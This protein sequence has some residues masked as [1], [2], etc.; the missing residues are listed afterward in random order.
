MKKITSLLMMFMLF[1]G[2]GWAQTPDLVTDGS[3]VYSIK[4]GRGYLGVENDGTYFR[5]IEGN[6]N[7]TTNEKLQWVFY[8]SGDVTYLYNVGMAEFA[9]TPNQ[10]GI[11]F[12]LTGGFTEANS[13]AKISFRP[14]TK[15]KNV[16]GNEQTYPWVL[17]LTDFKLHFANNYTQNVHGLLNYK[18]DADAGSQVAISKIEG[19]NVAGLKEQIAARL[20]AKLNEGKVVESLDQLSN[21]K[22]YYL[23]NMDNRG[24]F[25]YDY[26][27]PTQLVGTN[28][29]ATNAAG[30]E[31]AILKSAS[32]KYYLYSPAANKFVAC[33]TTGDRTSVKLVDSPVYPITIEQ[34]ET[35]NIF[36]FKNNGVF[37]G[38]SGGFDGGVIVYNVKNDGGNKFNLIEV[39]TSV[40]TTA[41]KLSDKV[42]A[43]N[44]YESKEITA[45]CTVQGSNNKFDVV[46]TKVMPGAIDISNFNIDLYTVVSCQESTITSETTE[47]NLI[48][49]SN[50]PFAFS[51]VSEGQFVESYWY[52]LLINPKGGKDVVYVEDGNKITTLQ[53]QKS[54]N[55]NNYWAFEKVEGDA[56]SVRIYNMRAGVA[57]HLGLKG[58]FAKIGEYDQDKDVFVVETNDVG[59]ALR[60]KN[61]QNGYLGSHQNYSGANTGLG[62]W[63]GGNRTEDG[64]TFTCASIDSNLPFVK[65]NDNTHTGKLVGSFTTDY[66]ETVKTAGA[67]YA[68]DKTYA[69]LCV[70][71]EAIEKDPISTERIQ[72]AD[73]KFYQLISYND[74]TCKSQTMYATPWCDTEGGKSSYGDRGL[75][76]GAGI[77][78]AQTAMKF[79]PVEGGKYRIQHANSNYWFAR[80]SAFGDQATMDLPVND[81]GNDLVLNNECGY[82]NVWS[83]RGNDDGGK[84]FHCGTGAGQIISRHMMPSQNA[85][86]LWVVKEITEV[87]VTVGAAKWSTLCLPMPVTIPEVEGLHVYYVS[88]V[89]STGAMILSEIYAGTTIAKETPV[90]VYSTSKNTSDVYTFQV[91]VDEAATSYAETNKLSG[92]TARRLGFAGKAQKDNA[93]QT[94][95]TSTEYYALGN[96]GKVAFFPSTSNIVAANKAYMLKSQIPANINAKSLYFSF[97]DVTGIENTPVQENKEVKYYDLSGKRVLYPSNGV[98]ITSE[99][100]KLFIK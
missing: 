17:Q 14:A 68:Q 73:N 72:I 53:N 96:K 36:G 87:P 69:N 29:C 97:G 71:L 19:V 88:A 84:F 35:S 82:P 31:F 65:G 63:S 1:V 54:L 80:P 45:H 12:N 4:S 23:K 91:N 8:K 58:D 66:S 99:G 44:A 90:L 16:E 22:T 42:N 43:I 61:T 48:V 41:A 33:E 93:T 92:A 5:R 47:L 86:N 89:E 37:F 20:T 98:F 94:D 78:V 3:V 46:L 51:T 64:S 25:I 18:D 38:L 21:S 11:P 9:A 34:Y 7:P 60:C 39:A 67:T 57:K 15:C 32:N 56:Y 55:R 27:R 79:I 2:M 24:N 77:P 70:L 59:F 81:N 40:S 62:T 83:L 85:G 76:I 28:K 100:K 95:I 74:L 75:L 13:F 30:Y 50:F 6:Q 52:T 26:R 49:K 10:N